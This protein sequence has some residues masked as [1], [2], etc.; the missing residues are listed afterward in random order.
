[1]TKCMAAPLSRQQIINTALVVRT[2]DGT[3]N[4]LYFD[5]VRFL[6]I[7][8]PKFIPNFNLIIEEKSKLGECHGL[9]YPDRNEIHIRE[10]VYERALIGSGRDRLTM[11][12][13]LFHLLQHEKQNISYARIEPEKDIEAFRDPE[14]QAD[15]FGGELLIPAHLIHNMTAEEIVEKC[16]VSYKAASY[17][18]GKHRNRYVG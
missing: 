8:L 12:H 16:K 2:L 4:E 15:A 11:A 13:E 14:W 1:M 3:I 17:Q 10:D 5:I 7:K 18:L 6:E 9:T